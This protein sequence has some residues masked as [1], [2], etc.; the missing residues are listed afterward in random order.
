MKRL[1]LSA[2]CTLLLLCLCSSALADWT[3][4]AVFIDGTVC[5]TNNEDSSGWCLWCGEDEP[6]HGLSL[7]MNGLDFLKVS[8]FGVDNRGANLYWAVAGTGAWRLQEGITDGRYTVRDLQPG[9]EYEVMLCSSDDAAVETAVFCTVD[10]ATPVPTAAPT[11]A[12]TEEPAIPTAAP[13]PAPTEEPAVPTAEPVSEPAD[14]PA[15]NICTNAD[16]L[17]SCMPQLLKWS[18]GKNTITLEFDRALQKGGTLSVF[19]TKK[20]GSNDGY[21]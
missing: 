18:A 16:Q 5:N 13:T 1:L 4:H 15:G 21:L 20:D 8:W 9:T 14:V 19:Y 17:L 7:Q 2:I 12:P 10:D 3:C 6:L 11:P